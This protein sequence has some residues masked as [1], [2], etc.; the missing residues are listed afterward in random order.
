[1]S[2]FNLLCEPIKNGIVTKLGWRNLTPVQELSFP[3]IISGKNAIILAPTAGGKTE[4]A[5]L[6]VLNV[7]YSEKLE[8]ISVIYVSPIKA[9]LN[10]QEERLK[11]LSSFIYS[12]VFKWH[13]D[14]ESS[15][16]RKFYKNP[17]QI[18]MIT[19]ESLE[20][21][22][23]SQK[24]DKKELFK[25]IRFIVIDE[26]HAFADSERG[27]H[28]MA[29][30]ERIQSFSKF[31]IQ[32]I[33]LSATVGN[34]HEILKWMQGSSTREGI[35]INPPKEKK[36]KK[37]EIKYVDETKDDFQKEIAKRIFGKKALFFSNSRTAAEE[38]KLLIEGSGIDCH[39]HHSSINK[40]FREIAEEKFKI[41]NNTAIIATSTLELGIDIGDLDI[42]LQLDSPNSVSSFLQR[43]GRTG[44]RENSIAHFVFF[45]TDK[46][47]L[48]FSIAILNLAIRGWVEDVYLVRKAY[49]ILFQQIL[50]IT[51]S[52]M[53]TDLESIYELFKNIYSFSEVSK[54]DFMF[55]IKHMVENKYLMY[56]RGKIFIDTETEKKF[57]A[58]NFITLYS[59]FDTNKEFTVKYKNRP[60]GSLER[61]FV[62]A[63]GDNFQFVLAGRCWQTD[64]IDYDRGIL[65]VIEAEYARPPK[66]MSEGGFV[67]FE[68]AQEYLNVLT[69]NE[70]YNFLNK[71][72]LDLLDEIRY[73]ERSFGLERGKI[74][75]E[76]SKNDYIFYTY[77]G[78]RVNY[79]L[80]TVLSLINRY[81]DIVGVTWKGF[82]LRCRDKEFKI[83]FDI[84]SEEI[85]KIRTNP[86][87]FEEDKITELIERVPDITTSKFQR[88]LPQELRR[89]QLFDYIYDLE[90]TKEF[91]KENQIKIL[92]IY[93]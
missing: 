64:K 76:E 78:N 4:A 42:V 91:I 20:V 71:T 18:L 6:P 45:P 92:K 56:E 23:M 55:L 37:I 73:E 33:G 10:N 35:V 31:D 77:A 21:I 66:W 1:M 36:P 11:K 7:V 32:R 58:R 5:F 69:S 46:E 24:V 51:L 84:I 61:W 25:N 39:V 83:N 52:T 34:P 59:A 89:K 82:K 48:V 62:N 67:S 41:G 49:D 47:K 79:T 8:P 65:Y 85:N 50:A 90:K 60:I 63:L 2:N 74:L 88:Y 28:L 80:A 38:L 15:E 87:Y 3:E 54:E 40:Y 53:G 93:Y 26:I 86:N 75:I 81:Y 30:V 70:A 16:K 9:L 12:D 17:S 68:L 19:P 27:I 13:G 57:G 14:V 44:R 72:E 43:L 22:L 29:V